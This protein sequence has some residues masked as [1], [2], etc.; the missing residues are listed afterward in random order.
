MP[1]KSKAQERLVKA[2]AHNPEFAKKVGFEHEA[3]KKFMKDAEG[4]PKPKKER[5][6]SLKNTIFKK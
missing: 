3:A 6:S 2:A 4:E 5:F 1:Y